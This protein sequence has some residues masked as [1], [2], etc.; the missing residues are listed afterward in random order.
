MGMVTPDP[1]PGVY[2]SSY[3]GRCEYCG[4]ILRGDDCAKCGAQAPRPRRPPAPPDT[5]GIH[6]ES[7]WAMDL[8]VASLLAV[9]I[10]AIA[11]AAAA[12]ALGIW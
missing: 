6:K 7:S 5:G 10:M 4:A 12:A 11:A 1:P 3:A 8:L 9:A 2:G